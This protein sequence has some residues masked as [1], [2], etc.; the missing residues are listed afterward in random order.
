M[1]RLIHCLVDFDEHKSKFL[2]R[3]DSLS[4]VPLDGRNSTESRQLTVW[5]VVADKW[6]DAAFAPTTQ[7]LTEQHAFYHPSFAA[8]IELKHSLVARMSKATPLK[9]EQKFASI[10]VLIKR[11]KAKFERSGE[12]DR[13]ESESFMGVGM[14]ELNDNNEDDASDGDLDTEPSQG[15]SRRMDFIRDKQA[16]IL[17]AWYQLEQHDLMRSS[18]Q[19]LDDWLAALKGSDGAGRLFDTDTDAD[20]NS[21]RSSASKASR[22]SG[23]FDSFSA[24]ISNLGNSNLAIAQ[25]EAR[26][27]QRDR[28]HADARQ[29]SLALI[30]QK[31]CKSSMS[32]NRINRSKN[33]K[34][35]SAKKSLC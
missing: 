7:P 10:I 1:C 14:G 5:D 30:E 18:L 34:G 2:A 35:M 23:E 28:D 6:N 3:N 13:D 21:V 8:A 17:Y 22:G 24:S 33:L 16:Y 4:R 11:T 12:G 20:E 25:M 27:K 15:G 32:V 29:R 31:K 19:Q 26:E 9:C